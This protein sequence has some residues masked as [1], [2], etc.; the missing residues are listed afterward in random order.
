MSWM[1][2]RILYLVQRGPESRRWPTSYLRPHT[3]TVSWRKSLTRLPCRWRTFRTSKRASPR[4]LTELSPLGNS[5]SSATTLKSY[6]MTKP[7]NFRTLG[8]WPGSR[9]LLREF[10]FMGDASGRALLK[11][12]TTTVSI[13]IPKVGNLYQRESRTALSI[14]SLL[15]YLEEWA[16]Q[17]VSPNRHILFLDGLDSIFLNDSKY[18]E[19]LASLVQAAYS[20]NQQLKS[21]N[22]TGSVT[23][24]LRN[25]VFSRISM[26]VP[27]SQKMRDDFGVELDWRILSGAAGENAP[28]MKLVNAKA[29]ADAGEEVN[30]LAFFP[31]SISVGKNRQIPRLQ[32]FLNL[33][34]HTPRDL[35]RLFEEIRQVEESDVFTAS[36]NGVLSSDVIREGVLHYATRYFVNAIKN[37]FAGFA[38]GPEA[39]QAGLNALQAMGRQTFTRNE[40]AQELSSQ[41]FEGVIQVDQLLRLFFFAGAIGN[42]VAG[43]ESYMRFFHRRDDAEIYLKGQLIIHGALCHAWN[44]RFAI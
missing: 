36:R 19:S 30:V 8:R 25:D 23:L 16:S 4:V 29:S 1:V 27:D 2:K 5:Y 20:I 18:D 32:Y 39:A 6:S 9:K 44:I 11:V 38:G 33:T 7:A 15:P 22:A 14:F 10:G 34:R 26:R 21:A 24:L 31:T 43:R 17:A 3:I 41:G 12:A 40:F 28:L 13:P 42:L 35:L 37:E